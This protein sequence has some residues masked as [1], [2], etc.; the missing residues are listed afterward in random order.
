M[1]I[2]VCRATQEICRTAW[3]RLAD[4]ASEGGAAI[5]NELTTGG[6]HG[7]SARL[8]RVTRAGSEH[9]TGAYG[10]MFEDLRRA[11]RALFSM[12]EREIAEV[13]GRYGWEVVGPSP[14]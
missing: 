3:P 8:R 1:A 4:S 6:S 14:F 10:R 9:V 5:S 13:Y 7:R 11:E 12:D 2:V